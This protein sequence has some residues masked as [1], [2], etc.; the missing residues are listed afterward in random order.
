M[1][2]FIH[3]F[4]S[5][6]QVSR[7][8]SRVQRSWAARVAFDSERHNST[9]RIMSRVYERLDHHRQT[10]VA[11]C[12][13]VCVCV[14]VVVVVADSTVRPFTERSYRF[15]LTRTGTRGYGRRQRR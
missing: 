3:S 9:H 10:D 8:R 5:F 15:V 4:I 14:L 12:V 2:S 1:H 6:D 13:C 11:L 7:H